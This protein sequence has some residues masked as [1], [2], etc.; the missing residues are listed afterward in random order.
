MLYLLIPSF[1][2]T[3]H[4]D[5][6]LLIPTPLEYNGTRGFSLSSYSNLQSKKS[7]TEFPD[8]GDYVSQVWNA[9]VFPYISLRDNKGYISNVTPETSI[10]TIDY[11]E[12]NDKIEKTPVDELI[13]LVGDSLIEYK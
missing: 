3:T 4:K 12:E 5:T 11:F 2:N 8:L 7:P 10:K 13:D 6:P 1:T 9:T